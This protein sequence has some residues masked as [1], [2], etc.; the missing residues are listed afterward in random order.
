VDDLSVAAEDL[1]AIFVVAEDF[2]RTR[3]MLD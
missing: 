3:N 2:L 1:Q